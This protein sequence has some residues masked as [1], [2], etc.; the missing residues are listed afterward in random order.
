M[1][2]L[3]GRGSQLLVALQRVDAAMDRIDNEE[4]FAVLWTVVPLD[5]DHQ[6]EENP[7]VTALLSGLNFDRLLTE[8]HFLQVAVDVGADTV[9]E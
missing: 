7:E 5:T 4:V 3:G 1:F 2:S 8:T 6:L 9:V